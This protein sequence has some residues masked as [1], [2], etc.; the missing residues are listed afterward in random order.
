MAL[1][2]DRHSDPTGA[3]RTQ[4]GEAMDWNKVMGSESRAE[5]GSEATGMQPGS[6]PIEPRG[7]STP[8]KAFLRWV[9]FLVFVVWAVLTAYHEPILKTV[10]GFL[11]VSHELEPSDVIV[12]LSGRAVERGLAAADVYNKGLA[13]HVF[14]IREIPPD[15]YE[16]LERA[17]IHVPETVDVLQTI[18]TGMGVP[19]TAVI[20]SEHPAPSTFS[21]ARMVRS[22]AEER[23]YRS[24]IVI[25]SPTHTRRAWRT[26]RRELEGDN[27]R[28]R[29]FPSP[30]S[31]FRSE[32]WW[33]T[34]RYVR[35][36]ITEY[37]KL[38]YYELQALL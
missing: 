25:T 30:Y 6:E 2:R 20:E 7:G 34:R 32:D 22:L 4:A 12:C 29:M 17:G 8:R 15:G 14:I 26:L 21:E 11:V 23:G 18:L 16:L 36:V 37:Q 13:P 9:L 38:L 1:G 33:K 19:E 10:G 35:E 5:K 24:L 31:G 28:I 3:S 27:V